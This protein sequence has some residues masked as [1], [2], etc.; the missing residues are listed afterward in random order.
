MVLATTRTS[1]NTLE[2]GTIAGEGK[3]FTEGRVRDPGAH[4]ALRK[5]LLAHM[6]AQGIVSTN[7]AQDGVVKVVVNNNMT[8]MR[9][10][11][12]KTGTVSATHLE[13]IELGPEEPMD[14][15][16]V[17]TGGKLVADG[18]PLHC[19]WTECKGGGTIPIGE[20]ACTC[21]VAEDRDCGVQYRGNG[22]G[23]QGRSD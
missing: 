3:G 22:H 19:V 17:V 2:S 7:A 15:I 4:G 18:T 11:K 16:L 6:T 9:Y 8:T 20:A 14:P 23:F 10:Y 5:S 13:Y 21:N 1:S 12:D